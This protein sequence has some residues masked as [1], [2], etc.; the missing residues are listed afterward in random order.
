MRPIDCS[1]LAQWN[2]EAIVYNTENKKKAG[3]GGYVLTIHCRKQTTALYCMCIWIKTYK[4]HVSVTVSKI[5]FWRGSVPLVF[6]A[7]ELHICCVVMCFEHLEGEEGRSY[8]SPSH[9]FTIQDV[10]DWGNYSIRWVF[11]RVLLL[12]IICG[13]FNTISLIYTSG[14]QESQSDSW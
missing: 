7:S 1:G 3:W 13:K 5:E 12:W 14:V 2:S 11:P 6:N 4:I 8:I 9:T 10:S